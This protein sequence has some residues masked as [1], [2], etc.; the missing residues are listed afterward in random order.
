MVACNVYLNDG[1]AVSCDAKMVNELKRKGQMVYLCELCG[2]GY[3][4]METAEQCEQ[5]C[6]IHGGCSLEITR[7]AVYKPAVRVMSISA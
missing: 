5:Y 1:D 4:D 6:D 2:F 3:E 7:K